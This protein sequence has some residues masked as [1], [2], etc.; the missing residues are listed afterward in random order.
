MEAIEL[1]DMVAEDPKLQEILK[2]FVKEERLQRQKEYFLGLEW[3]DVQANPRYL[4]DL[5]IRG[6]LRVTNKS[7]KSIHYVLDDLE[8]T[9]K[10]LRRLAGEDVDLDLKEPDDRIPDDFLN[11]LV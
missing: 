1:Y 2:R 4:S 5:A 9:D 10:V 6:I 8:L 11:T 7:N 3:C